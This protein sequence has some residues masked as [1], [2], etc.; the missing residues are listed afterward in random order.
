[1]TEF[2]RAWQPVTLGGGDP[3]PSENLRLVVE[4]SAVARLRVPEVPAA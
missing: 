2:D 4:V 1:M 3:P